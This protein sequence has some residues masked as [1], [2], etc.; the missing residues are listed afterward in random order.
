MEI[1]KSYDKMFQYLPIYLAI[2]F[3]NIAKHFVNT[4][5]ITRVIN[6][7]CIIGVRATN[8]P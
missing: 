2:L 7:I 4:C 1:L 5:C 6:T 8:C 3:W